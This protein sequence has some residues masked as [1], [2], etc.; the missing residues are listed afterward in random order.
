LLRSSVLPT[1]N[2]QW[3]SGLTTPSDCTYDISGGPPEHTI[4]AEDR[5]RSQTTLGL[6]NLKKYTSVIYFHGVGTPQRHISISNFLDHFDI[7]G[8]DQEKAGIG[9]PRNFKYNADLLDDG[10]IANYIEFK[11]IVEIKGEAKTQKI[12]RVYE[13]YWVPETG[14]RFNF[15]YVALWVFTRMV[16]PLRVLFSSWRNFPS[17]RLSTLQKLS[18]NAQY[19]RPFEELERKYRDFENW[20]NRRLFDRG[21]F[22]DFLEFLDASSGTKTPKGKLKNIAL[23]W[24]REFSRNLMKLLSVSVIA[25]SALFSILYWYISTALSLYTRTE[26]IEFGDLSI[27]LWIFSSVILVLATGFRR[28]WARPIWDVISWTMETESD[29]RFATREKVVSFSQSLIR[30]TIEDDK[31]EN[32]V[33]VAHS[34]GTSIATEALLREGRIAKISSASGDS[35]QK[36]IENLKKV[37][38]VFTLGSP[39]DRIFFYFQSDRTFSHRYNRLFEE[40]RL[41]ISL[42][43]FRN[44]GI[45]GATIIVNFWSRFDPISAAIRSLRKSISE[46]GDA[47]QNI[48]VAPK[49]IPFPLQTHTSYFSDRVVMKNIYWSVMSGRLPKPNPSQ[50]IEVLPQFWTRK[51]VVIS[52]VFSLGLAAILYLTGSSFTTHILTFSMLLAV[53]IRLL[54]WRTELRQQRITACGDYL[55]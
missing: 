27:I 21:R 11:K 37:R 5:T 20:E 22:S 24:K 44:V 15:L 17:L 6:H 8:Q 13:A 50:N 9:K 26:P 42:P 40:Q 47:I 1:S 32:C 34:L 3:Q 52:A 12:I 10:S 36:K 54:Q 45:E 16:S 39:I 23:I 55:G 18:E 48:E 7:F 49:G 28:H 46:R 51:F 4:G 31:C 35:S 25:T 41:S 38:H 29:Q 30:S 2:E 19:K 53:A 33:I 14:N 43:P